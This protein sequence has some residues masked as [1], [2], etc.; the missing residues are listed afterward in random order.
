MSKWLRR[1]FGQNNSSRNHNSV[2]P[3]DRQPPISEFPT[4]PRNDK[5]AA[6]A[7]TVYN[8]SQQPQSQQQSPMAFDTT[9]PM[10]VDNVVNTPTSSR[11]KYAQP[12][13]PSS[14]NAMHH[15]PSHHHHQ[16]GSSAGN[17]YDSR[18]EDHRSSRQPTS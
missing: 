1:G 16:H 5:P 7:T 14:Y 6:A 11:N 8:A 2:L 12:S 13:P 9:V 17:P 4:P 15:P 3:D 10:D 18:K